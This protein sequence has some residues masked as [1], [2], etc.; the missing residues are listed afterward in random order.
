MS[1]FL[2]YLAI[3]A[4]GNSSKAY[5]IKYITTILK[6]AIREFT[7]GTSL[8]PCKSFIKLKILTM[9]SH[10]VQYILELLYLAKSKMGAFMG[11][12]LDHGFNTRNCNSI[13]PVQLTFI[14]FDKKFYKFP[15]TIRQ[16]LNVI[17]L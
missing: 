6:R 4:W 8:S 7:G 3:V 16:T 13:K 5:A 17:K 12:Q 11:K 1:I 2:H 14:T 15:L 10:I 9:V